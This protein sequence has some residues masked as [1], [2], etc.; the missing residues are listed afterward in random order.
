MLV[1]IQ[2]SAKELI[3]N[4]QTARQ[5]G[6]GGVYV[7]D[8]HDGGSFMQNP[9]YTCS[10]KGLNWNVFD[11]GVGLGDIAQFEFYGSNEITSFTSLNSYYG[12]GFYVGAGGYSS[13]TLPCFGFAA[14]YNIVGRFQMH[15]PA[16]PQMNTYYVTDYGAKI[17]GGIPIGPA[18]TF[19]LAVKRIDRKGGPYTFGPESLAGLSGSSGVQNLV[20]NLGNEGIGYGLDA[21]FVF[22]PPLPLNPTLSASWNDAGSMAFTKIAGNDAPER[23]KDNLVLA[24]TTG[25]SA[26][27]FGFSTGVEYRHVTDNDEQIGKK[28]HLGAEVQ[29]AFIDARAGLYQGYPS[30]GVGINLFFLQLDAALYSIEKGAYPGQTQEQRGQVSL[31]V[32]LEFDPNF[33]LVDSKGKSRRLK[34]RR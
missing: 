29:L 15:N 16:Y 2:T 25:V 33:N 1:S 30:Y 22:R 4:Y 14:I 11:L 21:G 24:A 23:Q 6:M 17:G 27:G 19:G 3:E 7:F 12:K 9:A 26:F 31:M 8:E 32:D 13:V 5:L 34:Q 18:L 10:V 20:A 28:I